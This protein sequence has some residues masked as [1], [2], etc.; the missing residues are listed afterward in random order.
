MK[1]SPESIEAAT[2]KL[3]SA[4]QDSPDTF[5]TSTSTPETNPSNPAE[6]A[7]IIARLNGQFPNDIGLFVFF[8]LNF[9]KLAPGEA[10]FLRYQTTPCI[11]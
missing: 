3:I 6:L 5:A 8:F 1:S 9:V 7:A 2:Q 11:R 4:A 10:M